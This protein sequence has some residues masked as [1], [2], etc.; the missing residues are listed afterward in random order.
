MKQ[1][2]GGVSEVYGVVKKIIIIV[3]KKLFDQRG[4]KKVWGNTF[5]YYF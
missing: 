4:L 1:E 3:L 5:T 2:C